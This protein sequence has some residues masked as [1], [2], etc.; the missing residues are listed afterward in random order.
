M[1]TVRSKCLSAR[2]RRGVEQSWIINTVSDRPIPVDASDG[3][4]RPAGEL[5]F[6]YVSV[7][8]SVRAVAR[9]AL[10]YSNI[11]L[12]RW[13]LAYLDLL[14]LTMIFSG[15]LALQPDNLVSLGRASAQLDHL[16]QPVAAPAPRSARWA[17]GLVPVVLFAVV[18]AGIPTL[19]V[20]VFGAS[21]STLLGVNIWWGMTLGVPLVGYVVPSLWQQFRGHG[22]DHWKAVTLEETGRTPVVVS[23]LG[24]WP[25][26]GGGRKN[27]LTG[28][29]FELMRQLTGHL[30]DGGQIMVGLARSRK[31]A[32]KYV[33]RTGAEA[34]PDNRRHLRWVI[35]Q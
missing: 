32:G 18:L 26:K 8:H 31:L 23:M 10:A 11:R 20:A 22:I 35:E 15:V 9:D 19:I 7:R 5:V 1:P 24:T 27:N 34:S 2:V 17:L 28:D 13:P 12:L 14:L 3:S 6:G 29:G 21:S 33:A 25:C 4:D 16:Q 30:R